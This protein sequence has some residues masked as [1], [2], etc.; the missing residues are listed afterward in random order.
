MVSKWTDDTFLDIL[1]AQSDALADATVAALE[2]TGSVGAANLIFQT[3]DSD[4]SAVPEDAPAA[5]RAF[6]TAT[7]PPLPDLDEE[8]LERGGAVF[9]RH[10]LSMAVVLLLSSLPN[11]YAAPCL[12]RILTISGDL[13]RHPYKRLLGVL[14][15]LVDISQRSAFEP[16]GAAT[17]AAQKMRLMHA[18]VRRLVPRYRPHYLEQY[19]RPVNH[20]DMLATIMGFSW[21][22]IDGLRTLEAGLTPQE[23]EDFYALWVV[24][25]RMVG[26][27][28]TA[29]PTDAS[30]VPANVAEAE[31][32]YGA[33]S[34]R[35]FT[36][37]ASNPDGVELARA[38]LAMVRSFIP[39][40]ARL[41]GLGLLPRL[42]MTRLLGDEGMARVGIPP[43]TG[44]RLLGGL[45][46]LILRITQRLSDAAP[47]H[48]AERLG[49]LVFQDMIVAGRGGK[50]EFLI[51][52]SMSDLKALA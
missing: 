45:F 12:G 21:L 3:V 2:A 41:L 48:L 18:G 19:G 27:H 11:G 13:G 44:H 33:Y 14:Q 31:Q 29:D 40:W 22:V 28:P 9:L 35:H 17:V 38:N 5:Y 6:V 50:V 37:A 10:G 52:D 49:Q 25:A 32:F 34:S 46:T 30:F 16:Q 15:L 4:A 20:E 23:E 42:V 1:R 36:D 47:G 26:I 8:Q 39:R 51:P 43:V 24:F 7:D